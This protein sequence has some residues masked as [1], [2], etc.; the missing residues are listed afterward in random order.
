[1]GVYFT[2]GETALVE[3]DFVDTLRGWTDGLT[4][5]LTPTARLLFQFL[6]QLEEPDRDSQILEANW[7]DFLKRIESPDR[8]KQS[9]ATELRAALESLV[10]S[11]LVESRRI[12]NTQADDNPTSNFQLPTSNYRLHPAIAER[13]RQADQRIL[14]AVDIELGDFWYAQAVRGAENEMQGGTRMVIESGKR[15]VPYLMRTRRWQEAST[16]LEQTILRDTTPA[17]LAFALP[18]L[19]QIADATRGTERELIDEGILANALM[20]AGRY[21]EAEKLERDSLAKCITQKNFR[22]ASNRAG[23]LLNLLMTTGKL[24]DALALSEQK[25]EYSRRAGLGPWTQLG[26]ETRRLQ[27]LNAL[28]RYREV[29]DAVQDKRALLTTLPET[30]AAEEAVNVWNVRETL[31]DTG[32]SA[33]MRLQEWQTALALNAEIVQFFH[34]RNADEVEVAR[35]RFNDYGPLL[36][37]RRNREARALL[38]YCRAAFEQAHDIV[39]LGKALSA[40]ADLEDKEGHFADAV[41]FEQVA[42]RYKYQ[43]GQPEDCSISHNNLAE[44][45][46]RAGSAPQVVLAHRLAAGVI[47]LQTSSGNLVN[48]LANLAKS[49]LP[50]VPPTFEEVVSIVEQIPGVR[51]REAFARLDRRAPDGDAAIVMVLEMAGERRRTEDEGRRMWASLPAD[52]RAAIEARDVQALRAALGKLPKE[53]QQKIVEQLRAAGIIGGG[54]SRAPDIAQVLQQFE[55]LLRA[56]ANV[57][58]GDESQRAEI[59]QL[60]PQLASQGWQL[61]A[62]VARIWRGEREADALTAGIDPNSAQVVRRILEMVGG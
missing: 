31:L 55:P 29:L 40:L 61:S 54:E 21:D 44:Y 1:M 26:D 51:F 52:V 7:D 20:T 53:Q 33:A 37:L 36:R 39:D 59:E 46:E 22:L 6:C 56:I 3:K 47:W 23:D 45:L 57:A 62:P 17:T 15:G 32:R 42:L 9:D 58:R 41:Q 2:T 28:G 60:L 27:I 12:E 49:P 24:Q 4:A 8:A 19:R 35:K 5:N 48:V 25:A 30:S 38:E 13:G 11:G 10:V 50:D 34:A 43:A 16:L 14:D 18:L